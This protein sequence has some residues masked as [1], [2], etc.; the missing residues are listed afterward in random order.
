MSK[1]KHKKKPSATIHAIGGEHRSPQSLL[2]QA[3]ND[4]GIKKCVLVRF[5]AD[6]TMRWSH[7]GMTSAEMAYTAAVLNQFAVEEE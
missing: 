7:Y 2:A 4:E 3:Y 5:Y 6:G 1:P